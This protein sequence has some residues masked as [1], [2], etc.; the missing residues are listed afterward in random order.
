MTDKNQTEIVEDVNAS[1]AAV[2][3]DNEQFSLN[4]DRRVRVLSPGMM[5]AKR[6]FRNRLAMVGLFILIAMFLF[7]FVGGLISPYGEDQLFY[8]YKYL[9]K[10]Y[11]AAKL[12]VEFR[13]KTAPGHDSIS[14]VVKADFITKEEAGT[15]G[16]GDWNGPVN[17]YSN[18]Y[19][20]K[21]KCYWYQSEGTDLY[22]IYETDNLEGGV[23]TLI[24]IAYKEI[25]S[26]SN[27]TF[28]DNFAFTFAALKAYSNDLPTFTPEGT[29]DVYQ[30]S[31]G[32]LIT[33]G[34][35]EVAYVSPYIVQAASVDVFL[36]R[37]FKEQ[38]IEILNA[39]DETGEATLTITAKK[40][41][42][43]R[44]KTA[45]GRSIDDE[46]LTE[47][48]GAVSKGA[49]S[50]EADGKTYRVA[51]E[52]TD[53]FSIYETEGGAETLL[54]IAFK[55]VVSKSDRAFD[56]NFAF[57]FAAL[58]AY[59]NEE[60]AFTP[61]GSADAYAIGED[62]VVT[63][64]G[65]EVA[66][67]SRTVV[68]TETEGVFLKHE[69]KNQI[70]ELIKK[71]LR[72]SDGEESEEAAE[73]EEIELGTEPITV[74]YFFTKNPNTGE[75]AIKQEAASRIYDTYSGPSKAHWL[76]TD[77]Y[78]MDMLTRLMYGGRVSLLIGFVVEIISTVLGVIL[79][80]ISG[81]FGGWVDNLIMRIVDIFY[82]IPS[83]PIFI[84]LGTAMDNMGVPPKVRMIYLMLI[85]GF[86]G[87]PGIARLVRGQI[88]S[89]REQ[90]FMTATEACGLSVHRRIFKHLVP[91]V[92]PQLIVSCTMG[93][94]GTIL[95]EATLSFL[96]L[97]VRFPFASWGNI[98]NDV[99]DT[100]VLTNYWFIWIPAGTLLLLTVLAFNIL[101]DGLRDAFDP[102]M[103]R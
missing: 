95:T 11:A 57:V 59:S 15:L 5:V 58:K 13:Y 32:G 1:P 78:G 35:E 36:T 89:L 23:D 100:F 7:S 65:D 4:D 72:D 66:Y 14:G 43:F 41:D 68:E 44:F 3:S 42:E 2:P 45:D 49:D 56:D 85:L 39:H 73:P 22:S 19:K 83:L 37:E 63:L 60:T 86:L 103:K 76:G 17:G 34:G 75:W 20:Y 10:N 62:G 21:G 50:F 25:V 9:K 102:K 30:L 29:T 38:V 61:E 64:A 70:I 46:T 8:R 6:F 88:L 12:N 101:G 87:W 28:D 96:G 97:G 79:G 90:E 53:L 99:N 92:I 26:K 33:L 16:K 82:C 40:N 48:L 18:V 52:G 51:A 91:N 54:G 47:L 27:E 81:Y 94:G 84:I 93:L 67:I 77:G 74:E 98:I 31:D 69:F 55:D 24:G 80:G 71:N